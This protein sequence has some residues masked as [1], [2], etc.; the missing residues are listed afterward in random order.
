MLSVV[1]LPS[2]GF[3]RFG[4]DLARAF[5]QKARLGSLNFSKSSFLKNLLIRAF[6]RLLK[7]IIGKALL[8]WEK[9]QVFLFTMAPM[10]HFQPKDWSKIYKICQKWPK[11]GHTM[12]LHRKLFN[13]EK[14][15]RLV[16]GSFL[17]MLKLGSAWL[18]DQKARLG[19]PK[20]RLGSIT[21]DKVEKLTPSNTT[22][23]NPRLEVDL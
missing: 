11:L 4:S 18:A 13:F 10:G 19:S 9:I 6:W 20:S 8:W 16:L 14:F 5:G 2:L 17:K 12:F 22:T 3:A 1:L 23:V 21:T 7:K 15:W